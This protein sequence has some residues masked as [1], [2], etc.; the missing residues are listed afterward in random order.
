M[1]KLDSFIDWNEHYSWT[2]LDNGCGIGHLREF[3]VSR[4]GEKVRVF[5]SDLSLEMLR[6]TSEGMKGGICQAD[7]QMLPFKNE[8]FDAVFANSLLHH[9]PSPELGLQEIH[10]VLKPSGRLCLVDPN[11]AF[12]PS[13]TRRLFQKKEKFS[14]VHKEFDPRAFRPLIDRWFRVESFEFFGYIA[15]PLVGFPDVVDFQ[16]VAQFT[17]KIVKSLIAIDELLSRIPFIKGQSFG[18]MMKARKR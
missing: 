15:Y 14:E 5:G 13:L 6:Y 8:V 17:P 2:I 18:F 12:L 9:L 16:K 3:L 7:S 10:R 4:H 1:S 11:S